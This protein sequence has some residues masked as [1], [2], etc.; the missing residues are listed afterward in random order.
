MPIIILF[1]KIDPFYIALGKLRVFAC[2]MLQNVTLGKC[3]ILQAYLREIFV[4]KNRFYKM[5]HLPNVIF[6]MYLLTRCLTWEIWHF[7]GSIF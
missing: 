2:L 5:P 3:G 1:K 6:Y 4:Y 7:V